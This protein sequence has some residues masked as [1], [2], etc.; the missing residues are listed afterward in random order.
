VDSIAGEIARDFYASYLPDGA[1]R[2]ELTAAYALH[3]AARTARD[4]YR[5]NPLLWAA[6]VHVGR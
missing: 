2:P 3:E 1:G 6:R 4:R 5:A